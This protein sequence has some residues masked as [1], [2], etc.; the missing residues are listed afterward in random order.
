MNLVVNT[1]H[2]ELMLKHLPAVVCTHDGV[3]GQ[4]SEVGQSIM[5][6]QVNQ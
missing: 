5:T 3:Q 6:F 1:T 4:H 2:Q